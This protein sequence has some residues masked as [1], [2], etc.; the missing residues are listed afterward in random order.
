MAGHSL[1]AWIGALYAGKHPE[2]V[3]R[4]FM[5]SPAGVQPYDSSTYDPYKLRDPNNLKK[6]YMDKKA[7][8]KMMQMDI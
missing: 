4:F 2:R 6:D 1:G 3:S 5:I 8:D 7:V